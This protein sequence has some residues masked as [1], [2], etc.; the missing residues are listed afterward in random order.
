MPAIKK[1][2]SLPLRR[3]IPLHKLEET[4]DLG[5]HLERAEKGNQAR[6]DAVL[7]GAH[8]DDHY[9][10]LF[11][12]QGSSRFMADFLTYT[13]E[14]GS[15]FFMLPGQVHQVID[16]PDASGYFMALDTGL[17][18]ARFRKVFEDPL[19]PKSVIRL[20]DQKA[21]RLL[22][23]LRLLHNVFTELPRP[24]YYEPVLHGLLSAFTGLVAAAYSDLKDSSIPAT[25]RSLLI[26]QQFRKLLADGFRTM[27][28]PNEYALAMNLSLSYLN[29]VV[30]ASTGFSVS[31]WIQYEILLEARRLL[32]YSDQS[33]KEIAYELGYEDPAYFSRLFRKMTRQTP[34]EFRRRYRE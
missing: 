25:P 22:E 20:T 10:F 28:G 27:K 34:G 29:E 19:L 21:E 23:C 12:E 7:M 24:T 4:T 8:R 9:I 2:R 31:H 32:Y 5:I 3:T 13:L 30:K 33:V 1:I 16:M 15:I 14:P 26:T 6:A 18:P 17:V 11:Q